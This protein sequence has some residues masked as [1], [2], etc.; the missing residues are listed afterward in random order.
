MNQSCISLRDVLRVVFRHKSKALAIFCVAAGLAVCVALLLPTKYASD[1]KLFIR[2][3]RASVSLDPTA[4]VGKIVSMSESREREINSAVEILKSRE[5][6]EAVLAEVGFST[7]LHQKSA[8]FGSSDPAAPTEPEHEKALRR[9]K[10]SLGCETAKNS[11]VI[12]ISCEARSP[13][14]AQQILNTYVRAF[15]THHMHLNRTSGSYEFFAEQSTRLKAQLDLAEQDLRDEKNQVGVGSIAGQKR[16]IENQV[17]SLERD[18]QSS[19]ASLAAADVSVRAVRATYPDVPPNTDARPGTA[20]SAAALASMQAELYKLQ[21]RER[22]LTARYSPKHPRVTAIQEQVR[23]AQHLFAIQRVTAEQARR[24]SLKAEIDELQEQYNQAK[25]QLLQLNED[26]IRVN[27]I[28]QE[29]EQ[30]TA[31]Y[32][33]YRDH[34]EQARIDG[35][36]EN[37]R[38]SNVNIA[39]APTHNPMPVSPQRTLILALGVIVANGLGLGAT[40]VGEYFDDSFQT[41][42]EIEQVLGLPVVLCVPKNCSETSLAS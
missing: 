6:L 5:L 29:V 20:S 41:P 32:R 26:E 27:A 11:N 16:M 1:A 38:I 7:V 8:V 22:E 10:Q 42:E 31:N 13:E 17:T 24:V 39:Q 15:K 19:R 34:L 14:A 37:D 30:L 23:Q 3:G 33:K 18:L 12:T 36:L 25:G 28:Q 35:A 2:I 40:F 9:L 4:T 21:I